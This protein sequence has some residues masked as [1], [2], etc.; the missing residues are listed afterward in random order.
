[1]AN[2]KSKTLTVQLPCAA[3]SPALAEK[4]KQHAAENEMSQSAVIRIALRDFFAKK[5]RKSRDVLIIQE[6]SQA[7]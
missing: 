1:M 3:V 7:S 5:A 2:T 6:S 4:V